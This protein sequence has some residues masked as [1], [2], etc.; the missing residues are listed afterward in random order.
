MI[1]IIIIIIIIILSGEFWYITDELSNEE[2]INSI[3]IK[4]SEGEFFFP[5]NGWQYYVKTCSAGHFTFDQNQFERK[6][7]IDKCFAINS[8]GLVKF[9]LRLNVNFQ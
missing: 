3:R 2:G 7:S 9:P 6:F 5:Q 4:I 8:V 1:I